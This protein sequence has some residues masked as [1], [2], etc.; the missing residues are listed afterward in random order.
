MSTTV[1]TVTAGQKSDSRSD[2]A[3]ALQIQTDDSTGAFPPGGYIVSVAFTGDNGDYHLTGASATIS[4]ETVGGNHYKTW[5]WPEALLPFSDNPFT[6]GDD[7]EVTILTIT[8]PSL[9]HEPSA[10]AQ[11]NIIADGFVVGSIG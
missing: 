4:L 8:I 6:D 7:Y 1:I 3:F 11:A 5:E 2:I 9:V 10:T